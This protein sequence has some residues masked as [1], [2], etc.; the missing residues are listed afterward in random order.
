ML[1]VYASTSGTGGFGYDP[2]FLFPALGQTFAELGIGTRTTRTAPARSA[3][4][5]HG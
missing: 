2:M 4:S 5:S 3:R 1:P